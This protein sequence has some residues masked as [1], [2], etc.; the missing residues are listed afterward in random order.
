MH[1]PFHSAPKTKLSW[2]I[3]DRLT[4]HFFQDKTQWPPA[5]LHPR[6]PYRVVPACLI[7][8]VV[9]VCGCSREAAEAALQNS[10]M[11]SGMST[12]HAVSAIFN[13]NA[14]GGA[15]SSAI[16]AAQP[17][18]STGAG[19]AFMHIRVPTPLLRADLP[20][21][22]LQA[23]AWNFV[24]RRAGGVQ[25]ST[26]RPLPCD[27]NAYLCFRNYVCRLEPCISW[28]CRFDHVTACAWCAT[29]PSTT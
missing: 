11:S 4:K 22:E 5:D 19:P 26:P 7:D 23:E 14:G 28:R 27:F 18:I 21:W 13:K 16:A 17:V 25:P 8:E 1:M 9:S 6:E 20:P 10:G 29:R 2:C 3:A 12:V 15:V 24:V